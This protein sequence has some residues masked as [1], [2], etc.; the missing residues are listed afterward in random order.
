VYFGWLNVVGRASEL[1]GTWYIGYCIRLF[2]KPKYLQIIPSSGLFHE[3]FESV[4][5]GGNFVAPDFKSFRVPKN[6]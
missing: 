2:N 3:L 1:I 6:F 4:V 5:V